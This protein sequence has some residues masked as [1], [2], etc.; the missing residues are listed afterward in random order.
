MTVKGAH[1][2][3]EDLPRDVGEAIARFIADVLAGQF[4]GKEGAK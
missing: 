1:F 3:Q 2:L 4:A